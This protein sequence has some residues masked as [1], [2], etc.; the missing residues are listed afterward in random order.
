M[1]KKK[2]RESEKK[3]WM[4]GRRHKVRKVEESEWG[5]GGWKLQRL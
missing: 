3:I 5:V 1:E 4:E 2:E